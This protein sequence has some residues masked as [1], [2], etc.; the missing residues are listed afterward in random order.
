[1]E[2]INRSFYTI[3]VIFVFLFYLGATTSFQQLNLAGLESEY[4]LVAYW[5]FD[6]GVGNVAYDSSGNG[7]DEGKL[8]NL[9]E[10]MITLKYQALPL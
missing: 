9:T 8:Y 5:K 1:M 2:K 4:G 10:L 6:E 3:I 7:N